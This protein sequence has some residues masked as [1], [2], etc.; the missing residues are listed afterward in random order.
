MPFLKPS[1]VN[2]QVNKYKEGKF[3]IQTQQCRHIIFTIRCTKIEKYTIG[4]FISV[5]KQKHYLV[6]ITIHFT[7]LL[8]K[9]LWFMPQK[10]FTGQTTQNLYEL[11]RCPKFESPII[12]TCRDVL[13]IR[14]YI[15]AHYLPVVTG[16]RFQWLP[17]PRGPYLCR[18]IVRRGH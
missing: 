10:L 18:V 12:R 15:Y 13:I 9:S 5:L 6:K 4:R 8:N 1:T 7:F 16:Q 14:R 11:L 17:R 2:Q 3:S